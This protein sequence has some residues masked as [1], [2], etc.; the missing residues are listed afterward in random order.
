MAVFPLEVGVEWALAHPLAEQA[1]RRQHESVLVTRQV[2]DAAKRVNGLRR[3]QTIEAE[4]AALRA[5]KLSVLN[6]T[7]KILVWKTA[8]GMFVATAGVT[9][10]VYTW[11]YSAH[12]IFDGRLT[13]GRVVAMTKYVP[14]ITA[15]AKSL[16]LHEPRRVAS[17]GGALSTTRAHHPP[18]PSTPCPIRRSC[19]SC[20]RCI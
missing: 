4:T 7:L 10:G 14:M 19:C 18:L 15:S 8:A 6:R 5:L 9:I 12:H 13:I 1:K 17:Q 20:P 16:D 2:V 11:V 3:S